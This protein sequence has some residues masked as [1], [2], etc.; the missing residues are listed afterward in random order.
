M[1]LN[2]IPRYQHTYRVDEINLIVRL[3]KRGESLGFVGMA[4]VG[5]SN[6]VNFL[7]HIQQNAPRLGS[8]A[9]QLHFPVVDA[10]QWQGTPDS[11]WKMMLE[12]LSQATAELP[13]P[14]EGSKII[15]ISEEER[16]L[17]TLQERL[18]SVCQKLSHQV[19]FVL[20]DF[21]LILQ[22]GPLTMLERLNGLRSA[23]NREFLSYLV[24]TRRLP[25]I[26]GENHPLENESKFYDLF[27]HNIYAL[28]PYSRDDAMQML[29]HLNGVAGNPLADNQLE[30]IYQFAGGHARLLR[31][32]FN[33]WVEEGVSG[34]RVTYFADKSDIK[35][36]CERILLSLHEQEKEVALQV[37]RGSPGAEHQDTIDHL[38]RRGVLISL[39]PVT[40]F[41]LIFGQF[42]KAYEQ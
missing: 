10:T 29:K 37:A 40:W 41:S 21:D 5:K 39:E 18:K 27:R 36:E 32:V 1:P 25:H 35:Q 42:L 17:N 8:E 16:V 12:A 31:L 24:L 4:G 26:L 15:P 11:L 7:R 23:G 30:R 6:I 3:A 38:M 9:G 33:I 34:I 28:E 2:V 20:D 14:I 22:T 13:L 19:M